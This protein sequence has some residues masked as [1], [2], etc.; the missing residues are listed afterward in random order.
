VALYPD[1]SCPNFDASYEEWICT[2]RHDV[3]D[4]DLRA[5]LNGYLNGWIS[6]ASHQQAKRTASNPERT[7][8]EMR[9]LLVEMEK[10]ANDTYG[11]WR[12]TL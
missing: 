10:E 6:E 4:A 9:R 1:R 11:M 2:C 3:A 12:Q 7:L 8:A 5:V